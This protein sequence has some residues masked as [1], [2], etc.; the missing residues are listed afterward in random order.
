MARDGLDAQM[1][2]IAGAAEVGVGTVYRHFK[3]K[4]E[5]VDALAAER[6][7][8]LRE[9]AHEA[10]AQEDPWEAFERFI[11]ASARIQT[12]D[13]ALSEV[14]TSRPE[15]MRRAAE[16]V[17]MLG[18]VSQVLGRAQAAGAVR[19]DAHPRDIPMLMCALAG[20][21]RN[22]NA[23]PDRYIGIVLDG[24]RGTGGTRSE[25]PPVTEA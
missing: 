8:R 20:T 24:L 25:L 15:T 12:E 11:R 10:L 9:L 5:L 3:T 2:D 23:S 13:R 1:E 16:S 22:P 4:D 17:G 14:L 6:F 7:E 21:F 18:L 19:E